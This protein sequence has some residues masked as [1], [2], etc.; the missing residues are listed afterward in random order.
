MGDLIIAELQR[1]PITIRN[2]SNPSSRKI[3]LYDRT[4]V[5][6]ATLSMRGQPYHG[7]YLSHYVIEGRGRR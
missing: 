4:T 1:R 7:H 3:W 2:S 5:Q 6:G